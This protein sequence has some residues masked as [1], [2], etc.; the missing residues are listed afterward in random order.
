M[1]EIVKRER[2]ELVGEKERRMA[3]WVAAGGLDTTKSKSI[4]SR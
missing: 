4:S 2:E 3:S 1:G